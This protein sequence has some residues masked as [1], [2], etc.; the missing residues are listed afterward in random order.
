MLKVG[1]EEAL[2][3]KAK[4]FAHP[5]SLLFLVS[6]PPHAFRGCSLLPIALAR[7]FQS[8]LRAFIGCA[9][10]VPPL[11]CVTSVYPSPQPGKGA[12]G[13]SMGGDGGR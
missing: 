13:W 3:T 2:V 11:P 9:V 10:T 12:A 7:I 5:E 6:F 8:V 4:F 1:I